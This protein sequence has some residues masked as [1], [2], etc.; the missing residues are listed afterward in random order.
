MGAAGS[1]TGTGTVAGGGSGVVVHPAKNTARL[2]ISR[3]GFSLK[4]KEG[5]MFIRRLKNVMAGTLDFAAY[6]KTRNVP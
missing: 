5:E 2:V 6:G 3:I 4:C 1:G